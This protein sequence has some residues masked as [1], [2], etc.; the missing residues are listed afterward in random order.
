MRAVISRPR[1]F[2]ILRA[3]T[4]KHLS[5]ISLIKLRLRQQRRGD[6]T[7]TGFPD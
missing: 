1:T 2:E 7:D 3:L 5:E 4:E 6:N